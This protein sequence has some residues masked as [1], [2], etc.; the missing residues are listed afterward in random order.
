M[1]PDWPTSG[2]PEQLGQQIVDCIE[3]FLDRHSDRNARNSNDLKDKLLKWIR[4]VEPSLAFAALLWILETHTR[5]QYQLVA[6]ELLDRASLPCPLTLA[7]LMARVLPKFEESAKTVPQFLRRQFGRDA[8]ILCLERL[9]ETADDPLLLGK[10]ATMRWYMGRPEERLT[11]ESVTAR[12][13]RSIHGNNVY[14]VIIACEQRRLVLHTEF[15]NA[16]S[17]KGVLQMSRMSRNV[18]LFGGATFGGTE[19]RAH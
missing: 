2:T 3:A 1:K 12:Q 19:I 18:A 7:Q 8:V 9:R 10:I 15:A 5:Y 17:K 16:G 14:A 11:A 6:G 4:R 13:G